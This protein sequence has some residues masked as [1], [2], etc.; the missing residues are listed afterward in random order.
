MYLVPS[1]ATRSVPVCVSSSKVTEA[2]S[3]SLTT[4]HCKPSLS[5]F[6]STTAKDV[7]VKATDDKRLAMS[8]AAYEVAN[9]ADEAV[10]KAVPGITVEYLRLK[11]VMLEAGLKLAEAP[12]PNTEYAVAKLATIPED[13]KCNAAWVYGNPSLED[14]GFLALARY[15]LPEVGAELCAVPTIEREVAYLHSLVYQEFG[16]DPRTAWS[17]RSPMA[18]RWGKTS[19]DGEAVEGVTVLKQ[20]GYASTAARTRAY[21]MYD[22]FLVYSFFLNNGTDMSG[23]TYVSATAPY[24]AQTW[25]AFTTNPQGPG[26]PGVVSEENYYGRNSEEGADTD[27]DGVVFIYM[28]II[29][30]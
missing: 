16:F 2:A 19:S 25:G 30:L 23:T 13:G 3:L 9:A 26:E 15:A 21:A 7:N 17:D 22:E 28:Y 20:G 27:G 29:I 24:L 10:K 12:A 14:Y 18:A 8:I 4:Y 5:P 6:L 1:A 11:P